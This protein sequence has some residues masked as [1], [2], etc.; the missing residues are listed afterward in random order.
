[1]QALTEKQ[2]AFITAFTS[3]PSCI[4][5]ASKSAV[6][7]GYSEK[8][9]Y[10][11][12][13][14][15]LEKPKIKAAVDEALRE[16]IGGSLAAKAVDFLRIIID[17]PDALPKLKMDAAKTLL[18]RAGLIAPRAAEQKPS[19]SQTD[20]TS[21]SMEEL[22]AFILQGQASLSQGREPGANLSVVNG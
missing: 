18:D 8:S 16:Q 22:E 13:R 17:D 19:G 12:G 4:G 7:A 9:A 6:A 10:E 1:M 21:L 11:I 15:Q 14:Q 5:N 2:S 20:L 3:T